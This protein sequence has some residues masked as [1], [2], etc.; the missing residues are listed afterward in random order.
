MNK[1]ALRAAARKHPGEILQPYDLLIEQ[2]GFDAICT[3]SEVMG[4]RHIY[5]PSI[6]T[7]F[8]KCVE[9]EAREE[10]EKAGKGLSI[11]ARL[12]RKYGFSERQMR[13]ILGD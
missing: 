6:R 10:L 11:F 13:R 2:D 3:V 4:G 12:A 9:A 8:A 7:I 1:E 5:V